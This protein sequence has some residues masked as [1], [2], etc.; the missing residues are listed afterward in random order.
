MTNDVTVTGSQRLS[1]VDAETFTASGSATVEGDVNTDLLDA[2]GS[3]DVGGSVETDA[4]ECS[5]STRIEGDLDGDEV[6]TSGSLRVDGRAEV[7]RLNASGSVRL[8]PLSAGTVETEG[9]LSATDI[10]ATAVTVGGVVVAEGVTV[11]TFDL[12]AAGDST[13]DTIEADEIRVERASGLLG[14]DLLGG[15]DA[16]L[17][18]DRITGRSV[19]LEAVTA[20]RV[21][22]E[23]VRIG[24][25]CDVATVVA[26]RVEVHDRATVGERREH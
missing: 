24:P 25:D 6:S 5:G 17:R 13:I 14:L 20:D 9:S 15:S 2:S 16:R 7:T 18:A 12:E 4:L 8:G 26:E 19:A 3:L 22:G 11:D 1:E 10:D 21:E 23:A